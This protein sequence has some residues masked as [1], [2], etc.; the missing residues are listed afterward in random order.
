MKRE[1]EAWFGE[2]NWNTSNNT[3]AATPAPTIA[4]TDT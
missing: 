3:P 1:L 4:P 2:R